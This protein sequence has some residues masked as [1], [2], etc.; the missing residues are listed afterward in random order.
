MDVICDTNIWYDLGSGLIKPKEYKN[1]KLWSTYLSIDE[2]SRS[3]KLLDDKLIENVRLSIQKMIVNQNV[4]YEPP[5]FRLL[6]ESIP[7]YNYD[8]IANDFNILDF[9]KSIASNKQLT[10]DDKQK[11]RDYIAFRKDRLLKGS[12]Y[13]TKLIADFKDCFKDKS[14]LKKTRN[15]KISRD[16]IS[17]IVKSITNEDLPENFDWT[18]VE[19]FEKTLDYYFFKLETTSMK[20]KK[21]DWYDLAFLVYVRPGQKI[22]TKDKRLKAL[23]KEAGLIDYLY[24]K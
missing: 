16:F 13:F 18:T 10:Q 14:I 5:F 17:F 6:V 24:D 9:T 20:I 12:E 23:I 7:D 21:N 1:C 19:L 3:D 8:I 22:W 2:L 15:T 4:I 11:L